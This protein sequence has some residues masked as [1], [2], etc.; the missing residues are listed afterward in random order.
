MLALTR[1]RSKD[2]R[3]ECWHIYFGDVRVGTIGFAPACR[4]MSISGDGAAA[5]SRCRNGLIA[6]TARPVASRPRRDFNSAWRTLLPELTE[7]DFDAWRAERD[8]TARKYA[9]SERD[10]KMPSQ[11]SSALML[12]ACGDTFDSH[13]PRTAHYGCPGRRRDPPMNLRHGQP[14]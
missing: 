9:M 4:L 7:A 8:W 12:C 1:R 3:E 5:S 6:P 2:A 11:I 13:R 14:T 10:E